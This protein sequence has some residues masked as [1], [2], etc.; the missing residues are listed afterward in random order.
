MRPP[1]ALSTERDTLARY[2]NDDDDD[3][4]DDT[5]DTYDPFYFASYPVGTEVDH[6]HNKKSWGNND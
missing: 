2:E 6:R 1:K 4:E 3:D 5:N